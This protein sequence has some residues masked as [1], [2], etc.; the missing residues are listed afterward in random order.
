VASMGLPEIILDFE[1]W[2]LMKFNSPRAYKLD[3]WPD[4]AKW[5]NPR[6]SVLGLQKCE[7]HT[8]E[9][10]FIINNLN[11]CDECP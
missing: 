4:F 8:S 9:I 2:S 7:S 1:R 5:I 11:I 3:Y 10:N 6:V